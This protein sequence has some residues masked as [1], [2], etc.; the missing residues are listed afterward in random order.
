MTHDE[1][2]DAYIRD[3]RLAARV[4]TEAF[5]RLPSFAEAIRHAALCHWLSESE[6]PV[7]KKHRHQHRISPA[8]LVAAERR[9][10]SAKEALGAA[11]NF[12]E[13]YASVERAIGEKQGLSDLAFYDI[14]HRIGAFRGIEPALVYLHRGTREGARA[15]GF[16]GKTLDPGR[17]PATFSRLSP[18][19]NEDC[20]C[21]YKRELRDPQVPPRLQGASGCVGGDRPGARRC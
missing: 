7:F 17:L 10:Q 21:I 8:L 1:I 5:R 20:L 16:T 13:L 14:A 6:P 4:E 3:H 18:A 15:L 11:A 9:L 12:E 2:V 19:E